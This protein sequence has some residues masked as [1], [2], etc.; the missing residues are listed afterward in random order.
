[1]A[2][3]W[4]RMSLDLAKRVRGTSAPDLAMG[5]LFSSRRQP[6]KQ[7]VATYHGLQG[8]SHN[9]QRYTGPQH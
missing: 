1:M 4:T 7:A 2:L 8:L 5:V 9:R 3:R 6:N